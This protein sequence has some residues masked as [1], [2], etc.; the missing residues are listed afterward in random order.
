M[1]TTAKAQANKEKTI[2]VTI[3]IKHPCLIVKKMIMPV[4]SR[5]KNQE[6]RIK[7]KEKSG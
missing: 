4:C 3:F 7:T 2:P 6:P 1:R 5:C